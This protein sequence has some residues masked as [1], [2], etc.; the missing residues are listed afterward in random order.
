ML[1]EGPSKLY[2]A[3]STVLGLDDLVDAQTALTQARTTRDSAQKDAD[4]ERKSLLAQLE[5]PERRA[6]PRAAGRARKEGLGPR[7]SLA[8]ILA[9]EPARPRGPTAP[10]KS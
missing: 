5:T 6:R 8:A 3:L 10:S 7:A 2:D 9:G 1:D 4:K